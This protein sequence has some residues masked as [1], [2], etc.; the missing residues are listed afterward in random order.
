[1]RMKGIAGASLALLLSLTAH[2]APAGAQRGLTHEDMI[3][4]ARLGDVAVSPDGRLVVYQV[5]RF[6]YDR[7]GPHT[8]LWLSEASGAG[9]PRRL[10]P[11]EGRASG[12]A[13]LPDGSGIVYAAPDGDGVSQLH[14]LDLASGHAT[15]LTRLSTGASRPAIGPDGRTVAF[16]SHVFPDAATEA[17]NA[18]RLRALRERPSSERIYSV[19][20]VRDYSSNWF[21]G[22]VDHLFTVALGGGEPRDLLV[23]SALAAARGWSGVMEFDWHPQGTGIVFS[24]STDFDVQADR[25]DTKNLYHVPLDGSGSSAGAAPTIL[26]EHYT[27]DRNPAFSP[28]GRYLAWASVWCCWGSLGLD[29]PAE[30]GVAPPGRAPLRADT[31]PSYRLN[32]IMIRDMRTGELTVTMT[33]WDRPPNRP[34]WSHDGRELFFSAED[35]GRVHLF[36]VGLEE[37]LRGGTPRRVTEESGTWSNP[38]VVGSTLFAS[39]QR[40]TSPP[41]LFRIDLAAAAPAAPTRVTRLNDELLRGIAMREAEEVFWDHAGRR[42]QGWLVKPHDF[43]PGRVYPLFLFPHGGPNNMHTDGFHYRW[44]AQLFAANG[45]V[46][47][48]PNPTGS[49]GFGERFAAEIQGEWG[50]RVFDEIMA[51]VDHLLATRPYLREERMVAAGA[52]YG[53]YLMNWLITRTDRFQAVF[54]HASIWNLVSMTGG[55]IIAHYMLADIA[56]RP[57]WEDFAAYHRYSPHHHAANIR[58]PTYVS[59]GGLDAG[60]PDGQAMELYWTLQKL[61]V[62]TRLIHFPDEG[63][64]ILKPANSRVWY[65]EL[66]DWMAVHLEDPGGRSD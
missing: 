39:L 54:T 62:P 8:S 22:R 2:V 35:A 53:G 1:M 13:W 30:P 21:E 23:G 42:I 10:T 40:T 11:E 47:F 7:P 36:R 4:T 14:R 15:Q 19:F 20:P 55:S 38:V 28:D 29:G 12:P 45:Y 17:E 27:N 58:T 26:V 65:R 5:Q 57:P 59:H 48:M 46:V 3:A 6:S 25:F 37:A 43:D 32:R 41:E 31:M 50:G 24:A 56:N 49:T 64:W 52:S 34:V 16:L 61:G 63:H 44:N 51:G 66:L 9:T 60:V 33:G 18:R